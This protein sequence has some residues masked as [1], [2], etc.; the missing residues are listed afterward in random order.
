MIDLIEEKKGDWI[1]GN[2]AKWVKE[3][4]GERRQKR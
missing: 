1:I 2:R 4:G 3:E